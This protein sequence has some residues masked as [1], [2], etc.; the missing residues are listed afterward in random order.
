MKKNRELRELKRSNYFGGI[1]MKVNLNIKI[2][3]PSLNF[4]DNIK[5]Q[6]L[7]DVI[8]NIMLS[9]VENAIRDYTNKFEIEVAERTLK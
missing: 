2:D 1:I 5:R 4:E 9:D 6:Q 3:L 8:F 7:E